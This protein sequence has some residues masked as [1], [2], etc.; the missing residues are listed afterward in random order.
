MNTKTSRLKQKLLAAVMAVA[1]SVS[2][3]GQ[4]A[5]IIA[6]A[7]VEDF[8]KTSTNAVHYLEN[9]WSMDFQNSGL[10]KAYNPIKA[11]LIWGTTINEGFTNSAFSSFYQ[12]D[13]ISY[14]SDAS[15]RVCYCQQLGVKNDVDEA[16][17]KYKLEDGKTDVFAK[18]YGTETAKLLRSACIYTFKLPA[19]QK[20]IVSTTSKT[21]CKYGYTQ[22]VELVTSQLITWAISSKVYFD[23]STTSLSAYE[24]TLL[25][26]ITAPTTA[27][28]NDLVNCYKKMKEDIIKHYTL[29]NGTAKNNSKNEIDKAT[30]PLTYNTTTKKYEATISSNAISPD[31]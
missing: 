14:Y 23:A 12:H 27:K 4:S 21:N 28:H 25:N 9:G 7:A 13:S 16:V 3:M 31:E 29:A 26:C 11:E 22:D 30:Y 2:V 8:T 5:S 10:P 20:G 24:T 19:S 17:S 6:S 18:L 1:C 15:Y